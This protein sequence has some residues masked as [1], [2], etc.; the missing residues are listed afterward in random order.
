MIYLSLILASGEPIRSCS[1]GFKNIIAWMCIA[2]FQYINTYIHFARGRVG[3]VRNCVCV[4]NLGELI[5]WNGK[6]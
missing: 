6:Q 4:Y 1:G 5:E 2:Q 3:I